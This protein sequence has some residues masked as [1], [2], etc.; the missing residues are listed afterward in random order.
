MIRAALTALTVAALAPG[1]SGNPAHEPSP[2]PGPPV[3]TGTPA[4]RGVQ[5]VLR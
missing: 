1:C 3:T 5:V 2:M 4:P